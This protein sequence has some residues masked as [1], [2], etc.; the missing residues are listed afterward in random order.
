MSKTPKVTRIAA[1]S[2][3]PLSKNPNISSD[4]G[5]TALS[6]SMQKFGFTEPGVLDINNNILAGTH[7]N[8][9]AEILPSSDV[10]IIES[11]GTERIFV[12]RT[13]LDIN[14]PD[15]TIAT[16]SKELTYWSNLT[17]QIS[18]NIDPTILKSDISD[19][20]DLSA[21][22]DKRDLL[23][24]GVSFDTP[25]DFS[26]SETS[27]DSETSDES[28]TPSTFTVSPGEIWKLGNHVLICGDSTDPGLTS[29]SPLRTPPAITITSPPYGVGK[30][31]ES[32]GI[33]EWHDLM[34][35]VFT[36]WSFVPMLCVNLG[37]RH[38]GN[39]GWDSHT[40]GLLVDSLSAIGYSLVGT[41][42]WV[43]QPAW[44]QQPY[45]RKSYKPVDEYE[46]IGFFSLDKPKFKDRLTPQENNDWGYRSV[47]HMNS[48]SRN[49]IHTA[50]F[51]L[52]LP[53]RCIRLMTDEHNVIF[54]PFCGSGT[55]IIAAEA[56]NRYCVGIEK[57]PDYCAVA[58]QRFLDVTGTM[59]ELAK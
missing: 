40:Y 2:L 31:Y 24:M 50:M 1:S 10:I 27:P 33:P 56:T 53:I 9:A 5:R 49:D 48:V 28:A 17:A 6:R 57:S 42:I 14:S 23:K 54:D 38:T 39:D 36:Q 4:R 26:D 37:D 25:T 34:Q 52:E 41:R 12:K 3:I 21:L 11:D 16:L 47:W 18:I 15:P 32:G 45:W 55:T 8:E 13:D 7:R 29:L 22:V 20:L 35:A 19:G 43:K 51:P 44:S 58:L 30:D 59:P 46:Y